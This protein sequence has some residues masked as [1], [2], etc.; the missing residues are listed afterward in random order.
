MTSFPLKMRIFTP[1]SNRTF[2]NVS[3]AV[4][5]RFLRRESQRRANYSCKMF[6]LCPCI[7]YIRMNGR[8]ERQTTDDNRAIDAYGIAVALSTM[9]LIV[10]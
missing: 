7:R 1:L 8:T 10:L 9:T 2:E 5:P 3:L 4:H 6:S